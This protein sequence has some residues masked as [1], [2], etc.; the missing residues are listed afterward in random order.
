MSGETQEMKAVWA[1]IRKLI[2]A[3]VSFIVCISSYIA[4]INFMIQYF[5]NGREILNLIAA[6]LFYII[7]RLEHLEI[8]QK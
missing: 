5:D 6:C 7:A 4:F 3:I 2:Y 8:S 1:D